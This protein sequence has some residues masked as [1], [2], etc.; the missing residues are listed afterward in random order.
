MLKFEEFDKPFEVY[1][2]ANYLPLVDI[3]ARRMAIV[4]KNIKLDDCPT[5]SDLCKKYLSQECDE[6]CHQIFG[7]LKS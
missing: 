6:L 3:D 5:L 1:T 2:T 7:E 4:Y